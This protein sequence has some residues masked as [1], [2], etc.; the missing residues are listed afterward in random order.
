MVGADN[1]SSR[2]LGVTDVAVPVGPVSSLR[3]QI[4]GPLRRLLE[5]NLSAGEAGSHLPRRGNGY[6]FAAGPARLDLIAFRELA[7]AAGAELAEHRREAALDRY[8]EAL[9]LWHGA[10]GEGLA[11][12]PLA[13]PIFA[14]LNDQFFE[15]GDGVCRQCHEGNEQLCGGG[16]LVGFGPPG[17]FAEYLVVPHRHVVAVRDQPDLK[18]EMLAPLTD[19]G[20]T[21][22]RGM[23]KLRAAGKL[24]AARTVV[25]NGIGGLGAHAV[26]YA[27]LL[28]AGATVVGFCTQ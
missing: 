15:A 5:P 1:L 9:G 20:L 16:Q 10:A 3:L 13:M 12:G 17:G 14:G 27:R 6:L 28:G 21:P 22:Y 19:A 11:H 24:G 2:S 7:D 23:K 26:Q 4:L 25:V 18:P 8:V